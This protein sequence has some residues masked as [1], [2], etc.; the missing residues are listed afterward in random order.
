[1]DTQR[2]QNP[3][4]GSESS[5]DSFARN[6]AGDASEEPQIDDYQNRERQSGSSRNDNM[7]DAD[8]RSHY[9]QNLSGRTEKPGLGE[10]EQPGIR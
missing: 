6:L 8:R 9:G 7:S 10:S 2:N 4:P 3:E 1:M 5:E